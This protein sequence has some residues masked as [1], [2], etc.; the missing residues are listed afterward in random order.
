MPITRFSTACQ[1]RLLIVLN[2]RELDI[3]CFRNQLKLYDF[4]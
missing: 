4:Q 1:K 2:R 3:K